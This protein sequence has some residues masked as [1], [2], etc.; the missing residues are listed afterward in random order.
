VDDVGLSYVGDYD[1]D[2]T[3]GK[4]T[5]ATLVVVC[6]DTDGLTSSAVIDV[7]INDVND[8]AP[9]FIQADTT[10]CVDSTTAVD[11]AVPLLTLSATDDDIGAL[12]SQI[13]YSIIGLGHGVNYFQTYITNGNLYLK[14]PFDI[15]ASTETFT[16]TIKAED[17]G[18]E[19]KAGYVYVSIECPFTAATLV[20]DPVPDTP[21]FMCTMGG[22]CIVTAA[23][24]MG[25]GILG[26]GGVFLLRKLSRYVLEQVNA[27]AN[28]SIQ[29]LVYNH[30][31][32]DPS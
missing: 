29:I 20:R 16:I 5:S 4:P 8:N 3:V 9:T 14:T 31:I 12:N 22:V 19:S 17:R 18:T 21:C 10:I 7:T 15:D 28:M 30:V 23:A 13:D 32:L 24:I 25:A 1:V 6:T 11:L 2:N 26:A 27:K